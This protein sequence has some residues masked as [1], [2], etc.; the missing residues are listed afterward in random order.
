MKAHQLSDS[1]RQR[2]AITFLNDLGVLLHFDQ[3]D[4]SNF[5]VL[6]P[7]WVTSGVYRIIT[8]EMAALENGELRMTQLD[9]AVNREPRKA[10][11]YLSERQA[12][13][14]YEGPELRYLAD[15]LVQFKLG[16]YTRDHKSL[17]IPDLLPQH[18]PP[19]AMPCRP[20]RNNCGWYI[21]TITCL[22]LVLPRSWWRCRPTFAHS[23]AQR[24]HPAGGRQW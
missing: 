21:A 20:P 4:L 12:E 7:Y 14:R 10:G 8:S 19:K 2:E 16:Y 3:L 24:R 17:L 6:D 11:Q 22:H 13:L 9:Y 23:L 5:F 18:P 15:I 1:D